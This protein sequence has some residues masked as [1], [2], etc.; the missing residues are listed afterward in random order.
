VIAMTDFENWLV[1]TVDRV[2]WAVLS[3]SP[4]AQSDDAQEWFSYTI[5]LTRTFG[6]PENICFGLSA[7][8]R[9]LMLNDAVEECRSRGI[10]PAPGL[11]LSTVLQGFDVKLGAGARIP[12]DYFGSAAWFNRNHGLSQQVSRVQLL[13]PDDQG[14]FPGDP[15]CTAGV[16]AE[17]T[18]QEAQ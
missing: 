5:G 12:H 4:R 1:E 6:W 3:V 11:R 8:T 7:E 9:T 15:A 10:E 18:P 16:V 2:G 17:Q 13:W 14:Q